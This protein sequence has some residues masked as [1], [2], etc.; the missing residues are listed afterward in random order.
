MTILVAFVLTLMGTFSANASK[1]TT[2][3]VNW[4]APSEKRAYPNL[5]TH[6]HAYLAVSL[7]QQRVNV[8]DGNKK[9]YTMVVSSG[10]DNTTPKGTFAIQ[11]ERGANFYNAKLQEGANYWT[12]FLDHGVYLFH[13]VPTKADGSYNVAEAKK[14]GRPASHGC[15]R[16]TVADAKWINE[17]VPTGMKVIIK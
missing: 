3:A 6:P 14:L 13:S 4:Q 2:K 16:M 10:K 15:I 1:K 12:S 7:K 17:N 5:T 11:S 8:I 9:L